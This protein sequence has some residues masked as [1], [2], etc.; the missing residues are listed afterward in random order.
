MSIFISRDF[1]ARSEMVISRGYVLIIIMEKG[2][3]NSGNSTKD[4]WF[5]GLICSLSSLVLV[6]YIRNLCQ[7]H[8]DRQFPGSGC[9]DDSLDSGNGCIE[10][11]VDP[12]A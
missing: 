5:I 7:W 12:V 2:F 1:F 9:Q 6:K 8:P 11:A 10:T 4:T 3:D